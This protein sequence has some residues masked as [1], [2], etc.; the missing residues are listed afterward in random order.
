M[1]APPGL[2]RK[3]TIFADAVAD[4]GEES[5]SIALLHNIQIYLQIQPAESINGA[6]LIDEDYL[7]DHKGYKDS[8]FIKYRL[9]G[10]NYHEYD[11]SYH[12]LHRLDPAVEPMR[13]LPRHFPSLLVAEQDAPGLHIS[14]V[15]QAKL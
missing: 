2:L 12:H 3:A 9:R 11:L 1:G 6:A 4:I 8:D 13:L 14:S 7:R 15:G 10:N 5:G